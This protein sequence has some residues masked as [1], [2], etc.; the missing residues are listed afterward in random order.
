VQGY[1]EGAWVMMD[2]RHIDS[3]Y[4]RSI[5]VEVEET[6]TYETVTGSRHE[7]LRSPPPTPINVTITM[8]DCDPSWVARLLRHMSQ[9]D[10]WAPEIGPRA[11]PAGP[12]EGVFEDDT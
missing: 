4:A 5:E 11:L 1:G 7:N 2:R 9:S 12:H 3:Q 8:R 10:G 6:R